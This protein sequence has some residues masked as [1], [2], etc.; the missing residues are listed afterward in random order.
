MKT[1]K[2]ITLIAIV[3]LAV[4]CKKEDMNIQSKIINKNWKSI[5]FKL[6]GSAQ[7]GWCWKNSIYN[8]YS[9]GNVYITQGDNGGGCLGT[10]VGRIKKYKYNISADE[11]WLITQ[12][13]EVPDEVDSFMIISVSEHTLKLKRIVNKTTMP[14]GETWEDEYSNIP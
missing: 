14:P 5:A 4:R 8:F 10:V 12:Y 11:K 7:A 9:D 2:I 13:N 1:T 3:I 6:N